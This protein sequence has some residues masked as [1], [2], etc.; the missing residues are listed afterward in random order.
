MLRTRGNAFRQLEKFKDSYTDY[1]NASKLVAPAGLNEKQFQKFSADKGDSF[2]QVHSHRGLIYPHRAVHL[3]LTPLPP[4][5]TLLT[6]PLYVCCHG[7]HHPV[8]LQI[9]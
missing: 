7:A 2:T 5:S 4:R 6:V 1:M 3:T 9:V 8:G